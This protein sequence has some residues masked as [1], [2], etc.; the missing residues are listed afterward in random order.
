MKFAERLRLLGHTTYE[1]YLQSPHWQRFKK[2][3][4]TIGA[5]VRCAACGSSHFQLHHRTYER[6]G[7]ELTDD[8]VPLCE[9]HHEAVHKWLAHRGLPVER[10]YEAINAVR[11]IVRPKKKLKK[12]PRVE[13]PRVTSRDVRGRLAAA[14][15]D[16]ERL[17]RAKK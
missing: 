14:R 6:L 11:G 13:L 17:K 16:F 10:T 3:Y 5:S 4:E 12:K 2:A 8:V 1:A 15:A 7:R 9:T